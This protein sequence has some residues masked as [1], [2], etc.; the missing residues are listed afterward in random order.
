MLGLNVSFEINKD[1]TSIDVFEIFFSSE[2]FVIIHEAASRYV[3]QEIYKKKKEGH[4]KQIS[5]CFIEP[6]TQDVKI[7]LHF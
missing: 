2:M 1:S 6:V 5:V 7:F 3:Q 4:L